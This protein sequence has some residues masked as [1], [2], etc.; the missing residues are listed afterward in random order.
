MSVFLER[1][2]SLEN[3]AVYAVID[4]AGIAHGKGMKRCYY[5]LPVEIMNGPL[6]G[7]CIYINRT[8]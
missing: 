5:L 6:V 2:F 7:F 4:A 8:N 1:N 3:P